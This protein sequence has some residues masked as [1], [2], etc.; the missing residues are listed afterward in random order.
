MYS[1]SPSEEETYVALIDVRKAGLM[2]KLMKCLSQSKFYILLSTGSNN[3]SNAVLWQSSFSRSIP[4]TQGVQQGA[5]LSPLLYS[6]FV[7]EILVSLQNSGYGVYIN[8][9]FCGELMYADDLALINGSPADCH[10][11]LAIVSSLLYCGTTRSM[12]IS[13]P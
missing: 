2:V 13:Q 9:I 5:I 7:D 12:L 10:A 4:I 6:V 8:S 11:M 3:L 1:I